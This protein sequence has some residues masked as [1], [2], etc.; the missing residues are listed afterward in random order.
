MPR[1]SSRALRVKVVGWWFLYCGDIGAG[2]NIAANTK[3]ISAG[4]HDCGGG[5]VALIEMFDFSFLV[6]MTANVIADDLQSLPEPQYRI[7]DRHG[8]QT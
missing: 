5:E 2:L 8:T 4:I 7:T 3:P 6:P 1:D